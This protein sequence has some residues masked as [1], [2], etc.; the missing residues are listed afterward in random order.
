[1]PMLSLLFTPRFIP[2]TFVALAFIACLIGL[3]TSSTYGTLLSILSL[4]FGALTLL[5]VRDLMQTKHAVLRNYPIAGH[6]RFLLEEIRPEMRQ[7][8]FEDEKSGRPFSRDERAIVYQRSKNALDKRPFGTQNDVYASGYEWLN[9]SANPSDKATEP[10]RLTIGGPDCTK[11]YR[12]SIFNISG[13]SFGALSANAI[14][15]LNTGAKAGG[16][17]HT[18]GEGGISAYHIAPGGDLIWQIG[19]GYYGCRDTQGAFC[20]KRFAKNA[21]R[22]Q[23]KMI[24]VKLSQGAKPGHGGVLPKVKI[25]DEIAAARGIPN[26]RD[27]VS[28]ARHPAFSTPLGLMAFI[29]ELR[30]LSKGKPVGIKLCVGQRAEFLALCK[31]MLATN[32]TPDFIVVDGGEGGTG[33]A[34]LEFADHAGLP[35]REGLSFAHRSLVGVGLRERIKLGASGKI[36]SAFDMARVMALGADWCNSARGFMFA[37]G[38]IQS[39]NCHNDKCPT[40]VATQ[41][42]SRQR[43]LVVE[44]KAQRVQRFHEATVDSLAE[45]VASMGLKHPSEI[46]PHHVW[47]RISSA[48]IMSFGELFP[49]LKP[50]ELIE[51]ASNPRFAKPW[52]LARAEQFHIEE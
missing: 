24:E 5:G 32:I 50:N 35:L 38:C 47:R 19:S 36:V 26:D 31:A 39:Q 48:Q 21:Q 30:S 2:L 27:C 45:L 40:G 37:L 17:A 14:L 52:K 3:I 51:G 46:T 25:T 1:M 28:P 29:A 15:A 20:P 13:M 7:Y 33:A 44:D 16:F 49:P 12:A 8:F 23:V 10:F 41:N 18:T 11:P 34:P 43:A 22:D 6:L 9:H 4:L 42:A